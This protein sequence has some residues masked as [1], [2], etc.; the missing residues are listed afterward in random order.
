MGNGLLTFIDKKTQ[1]DDMF[2]SNEVIMYNNVNDL[3][4]KINFIKKMIN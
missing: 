4:D 3:T 2:N 1:L